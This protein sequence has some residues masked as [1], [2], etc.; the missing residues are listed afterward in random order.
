MVFKFELIG[1]DLNYKEAI[2]KTCKKQ[3]NLLL[4]I[5]QIYNYIVKCT[6]YYII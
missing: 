4:L 2:E 6:T 5:P 1:F 3:Q